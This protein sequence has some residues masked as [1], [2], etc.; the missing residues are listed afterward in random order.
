VSCFVIHKYGNGKQRLLV[1]AVPC[2]SSPVTQSQRVHTKER[3]TENFDA[4]RLLRT[5]HAGKIRV[6]LIDPPY[7]T[8]KKDFVYNDRYVREDDAY[9]HSLW[10][11][12]LHNRLKLA[13]DL[14]APDGV[15][16]VCIN[17]DNRAKLELLMDQVFAGMRIGSMVWRSRDSTSAKDRNFSDVHEHVLMYGGPQFS[18]QG[19]EKTQKKY[20]NPDND[21]RGP[22]NTDPLTLGFDRFQRPN[23]FYPIQNPKTGRWY[24]CDPDRV[25]AYATEARVD[26]T[27]TIRTETMEEWIRQEKIVFPISESEKVET[28]QTLEDLHAA[29]RRRHVPVTPK[30]KIPL[31]TEDTPDL[32]FWVGK[33][34]G[35]GRPGFK[36]HWSDLRSHINPVS[37]WIAR[38]NEDA[39]DEEITVLR[40]K[41]AG[42]GTDALQDIFGKKTFSYPKPPSLITNLVRQASRPDDL[43]LDFFAGSGT[44]AEAVLKLNAEDK[45]NRRFILVSSTEASLEN[46]GYNLCRDVCAERIRRVIQGYRGNKGFADNF[47]YLQT[48]KID[49]SDLV[50]DLTP[51]LAWN[52]LCLLHTG[53]IIPYPGRKV[54]PIQAADGAAI[55]FCPDTDD[56]TIR[57]VTDTN[58]MTLLIY[59]DRPE[60]M[61]AALVDHERV[62]VRS[63]VQAVS[64]ARIDTEMGD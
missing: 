12:W 34:V 29:I 42:E 14:L 35:F 15:I 31:L 32:A 48:V 19:S 60:T 59:S 6:I 5:T 23:L 26:K 16:F 49:P 7:N 21:P 57:Q 28:W 27:S 11:D 25:W 18:F 20:K 36:K 2:A 1:P 47:A 44:T 46:L 62:E 37:S 24:P 8:G 13:R 45:G 22:W 39:D 61:A 50:L 38:L 63:I 4:L 54:A 3:R 9:R 58:F 33:P 30:K 10:L 41:Q 53:S 51:E 17:D 40:T 56:E 55:L 43:V 52:T 64:T